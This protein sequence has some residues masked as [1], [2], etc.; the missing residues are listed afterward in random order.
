MRDASTRQCNAHAGVCTE[1][2]GVGMTTR[3]MTSLRASGAPPPPSQPDVPPD[4]AGE[5]RPAAGES[6][7]RNPAL[8]DGV[9]G[10]LGHAALVLE[11]GA[12]AGHP[13][14]AFLAPRGAPRVLD[15]PVGA[16]R[17]AADAGQHHGV[18]DLGAA[19][20][21]DAGVVEL[22]EGRDGHVDGQRAVDAQ[23]LDQIGPLGEA[24]LGQAEPELPRGRRAGALGRRVGVGLAAVH[25]LVH[26]VL[27]GGVRVAV[28][29][30]VALLHAVDEVLLA[31]R[32][33]GRPVVLEVGLDHADGGERPA[34]PAAAL[35]LHGRHAALAAEVDVGVLRGADDAAGHAEVLR[36]QLRP[37]AQERGE[38]WESQVR[39]LG[40]RQV[41]GAGLLGVEV[42]N[43]GDVGE[44]RHEAGDLVLHGAV[45]AVVLL[46][47]AVELYVEVNVVVHF[48]AILRGAPVL[49]HR[50]DDHLRN[51]LA[52]HAGHGVVVLELPV[53]Q[54]LADAL[55]EPRLPA[56]IHGA[57]GYDEG[58][59][60]REDQREPAPALVATVE[61][62][63]AGVPRVGLAA[64]F[65]LR[66]IRGG[67]RTLDDIVLRDYV[68]TH[69]DKHKRT[70]EATQNVRKGALVEA[71][72]ALVAQNLRETV[73]GAGVHDVSAGLLAGHHHHA[74]THSVEGVGGQASTDGDGLRD[75]PLVEN[76]HVLAVAEQNSLGGVVHAEVGAAVDNDAGNGNAETLIEG[77]GAGGALDLHE[78][79]HEA[80]ELALALLA[81]VAGEPRARKVERVDDQQGAG[82]GEATRGH[83]RR[84][85]LPE[86]SFLVVAREEGLEVVLEREIEGLGGE[87]TDHVGHVAPPE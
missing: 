24:V 7:A 4:S 80:G 23:Q 41:A 3:G 64:G 73:Q 67:I 40:Y 26:H 9:Q 27:V 61:P 68:G 52:H 87:V 21:Q 43:E 5:K 79:V 75:G 49:A 62:R 11:I 58:D 13:D 54:R 6:T 77:H 55:H 12:A 19:L 10:Q 56:E 70:T 32:D 53:A 82:A 72:E 47:E 28:I 69:E 16:A 31:Q 39:E 8:G 45:H 20:A 60:Q 66:Q 78:A 15:Q 17:V 1:L 18:V 83:V 57:P 65:R 2:R 46:V 50:A 35:V 38:L 48:E 71:V 30:A 85:E 81:D 22:P 63:H 59:E 44:E 86:L 14:V 29:A 36:R 34:R 76:V 74:T 37:R 51:V 33:V 42:A 25:A 84:E